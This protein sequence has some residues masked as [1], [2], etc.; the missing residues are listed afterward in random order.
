MRGLKIVTAREMGR[1]EALACAEG[2]SEILFMENAAESIATAVEEHIDQHDFSR[3]VTLLVGKGNNGGDAL[4][5]GEILLK[6]GFRVVAHLIYPL[7]GCSVLCK[8]MRDRFCAAGGEV[9]FEGDYESEGIILDG[10][11]GTGFR[12]NA[13]GVLAE[14]IER[15]NASGLPIIAIDIPSGVDGSSGAVG[16]VAIRADLT[17]FLELPKSGFF[18]DQGWNHVGQLYH[19]RFGLEERYVAQ[20][21]AVATLCSDEEDI[22]GLLPKIVRTRH[23]Y[24]AGYAIAVAGSREMPGA[25]L[26]SSS[27]ALRSG[28]GIVRLFHPAG[29]EELLSS[30]PWELIREGW[31]CQNLGRILEES[32]RAKAVILGPGIGRSPTAGKMVQHL[33][34]SIDLP[35]VIDADALY[36][37]AENPKWDVPKNSILTPHRGEMSLLLRGAP[38]TLESCQVFAEERQATLVL[39]GAPTYIFQPGAIPLCI[40]RGD[41]GMATAGSGDVLTGMIGAMLAQGLPSF[42]AA[43]LAVYLHGAAGEIA[44]IENTSYCMTASTILEAI[45]EA[46]AS[47]I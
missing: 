28:C 30:A 21:E 16:S 17:V 9:R 1:I 39:K 38:T 41:P 37:L 46:F 25:A 35:T 43:A 45:P 32:K 14:A 19:G 20:A 27:A 31:D 11:V 18:W 44:A 29:I 42:E 15:A 40:T 36:F 47:L 24:Q 13:E 3:C 33:L 4:A 34:S 12:G 6:K 2:A 23:K 7:E 10:L 22:A 5:A 26:L 8:A